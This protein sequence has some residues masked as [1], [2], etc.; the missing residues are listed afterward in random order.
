MNE[1]T[2]E[3]HTNE[4]TNEWINEWTSGWVNDW[5]S[6]WVSEWMNERMDEWMHES[7]TCGYISEIQVIYKWIGK[8]QIIYKKHSDQ[9]MKFTKQGIYGRSVHYVGMSVVMLVCRSIRPFVKQ[10]IQSLNLL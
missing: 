1:W 3:E 7:M 9:I 2:S 5:M 10:A 4:Q 8:S 6:E